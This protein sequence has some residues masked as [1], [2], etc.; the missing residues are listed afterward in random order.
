MYHL[1]AAAERRVLRQGLSAELVTTSNV[2]ELLGLEAAVTSTS[3][4]ALSQA[5]ALRRHLVTSNSANPSSE[6]R[7]SGESIVLC[8]PS[9][10]TNGLLDR[11]LAKQAVGNVQTL[12]IVEWK[13][14]DRDAANHVRLSQLNRLDALARSLHLSCKPKAL[15]VPNCLGYF[16]DDWQPRVGLLFEYPG[17]STAQDTPSFLSLHDLLL[18]SNSVPFLGDRFR[19]ALDLSLSLSLLHTSGWLHKGIRSDNIIFIQEGSPPHNNDDESP[20]SLRHPQVLGFEYSRQDNPFAETDLVMSTQEE[21]KLYRHPKS[22][23][24]SRDRYCRA[25]DIYSLGVV[26]LEIGFWR[27]ISE[28]R[29]EDQSLDVFKE[30]LTEF[31]VPN[32]GAK[33]GKIY[34]E[35]VRSCLTG[36]L[37]DVDTNDTGSQ[38]G[39]Y[40]EVVREL[41]RLVA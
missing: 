3:Y 17:G 25:F 12:V 16:C 22:M 40:W 36:E 1:L 9:N 28:F 23:T 37:A 35:A 19:L 33:T 29:T 24:A 7:V 31:Y 5:S 2:N 11:A 15:R 10:A 41:A 21:H 38:R 18:T 4:E 13:H 6:L 8:Q 27:P 26:L 32:L 20:P 30:D 14:F 39:F 34:M